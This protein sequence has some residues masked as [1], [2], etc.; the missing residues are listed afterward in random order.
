M[1]SASVWFGIFGELLIT[2]GG[3]ICVGVR[4]IFFL[5]GIQ[6]RR[7]HN[8]ALIDVNILAVS[9]QRAVISIFVTTV[10]KLRGMQDA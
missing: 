5:N 3:C 4:H 8:F 2:C 1:G 7:Q 9:Q 10:E 6:Q